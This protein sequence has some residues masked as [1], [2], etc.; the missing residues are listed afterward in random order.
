MIGGIPLLWVV[1]ALAAIAG[2]SLVAHF[3]GSIFLVCI[4][5]AGRRLQHWC[6]P[7]TILVLRIFVEDFLENI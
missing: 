1:I 3:A 5:V 6:R 7:E 4:A 2:W